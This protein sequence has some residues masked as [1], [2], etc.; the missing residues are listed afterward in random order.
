MDGCADDT[1]SA[2]RSHGNG[3]WRVNSRFE[4]RKP[5]LVRRNRCASA[6]RTA[7][8]GG[9]SEVEVMQRAVA[10]PLLAERR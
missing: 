5:A 7:A 1:D 10:R 6:A 9:N 4:S 8:C 2:A 3:H